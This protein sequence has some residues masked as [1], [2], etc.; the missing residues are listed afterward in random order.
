MH[1]VAFCSLLLL[2]VPRC[3]SCVFAHQLAA[4]SSTENHAVSRD[5]NT[6]QQHSR[7]T[8]A[9]CSQQVCKQC[10][11]CSIPSDLNSPKLSRT[12]KHVNCRQLK[13]AGQASRVHTRMTSTQQPCMCTHSDQPALLPH[14][15]TFKFYTKHSERCNSN[16]SCVTPQFLTA[17]RDIR[18][19]KYLD[20]HACSAPFEHVSRTIWISAI[21]LTVRREIN[22]AA[23][24]IKINYP[25]YVTMK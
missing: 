6:A 2:L 11:C 16:K 14:A 5:V 4:R 3:S 20:T 23:Q 21:S 18:K 24:C 8:G 12:T 7:A 9:G 17:R 13:Q 15:I 22:Y 25:D 10:C 19:L 1:L